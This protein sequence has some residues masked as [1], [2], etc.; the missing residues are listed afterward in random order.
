MVQEWRVGNVTTEVWEEGDEP[1]GPC[2]IAGCETQAIWKS[3][4]MGL[5][6]EEHTR[7][8]GAVAGQHG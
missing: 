8:T 3:T 1:F 5:R 6:C 2:S 4:A 7:I